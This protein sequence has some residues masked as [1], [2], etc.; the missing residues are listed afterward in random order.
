M[1][2]PRIERFLTFI[3]V[4]AFLWIFVLVTAFLRSFAFVTAF[5]FSCLAPTLPLGRWTAAY[6]VPASATTSAIS[7]T[8]IDG[9]GLRMRNPWMPKSPP[10]E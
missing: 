1:S 2:L 7:A 5:F 3:P 6:A 9:E 10:S 4:T 8:I